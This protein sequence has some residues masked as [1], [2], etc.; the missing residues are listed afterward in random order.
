MGINIKSPDAEAAVRD[1][2]AA[3]GE[4]LTEAIQKAAEERLARIRQGK[5]RNPTK[6]LS[7]RLRPLQDLVAAERR[8]GKEMSSAKELLEELYDEHGLPR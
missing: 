1:L 4:G 6:P 5:L 7:D 8:K 3:T 2:A